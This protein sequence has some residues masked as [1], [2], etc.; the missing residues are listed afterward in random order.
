M[1]DLCIKAPRSWLSVYTRSPN[2]LSSVL[3]FQMDHVVVAQLIFSGTGTEASFWSIISA[4]VTDT[5]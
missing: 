2:L 1:Q 5:F 3:H 4:H